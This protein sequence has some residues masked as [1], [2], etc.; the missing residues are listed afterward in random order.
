MTMPYERT[1]AVIETREL[2]QILAAGGDITKG[3]LVQTKAL[4]LLRHYPL[5]I[6]LDVSAAA[7]PGIWGAPKH[8]RSSSTAASKFRSGTPGR[9]D[10]DDNRGHGE[11]DDETA[12]S[13]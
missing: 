13:S 9:G 12:S 10:A 3:G 5:D 6:D 2:L 1:K 11:D 4:R 7:L 8:R